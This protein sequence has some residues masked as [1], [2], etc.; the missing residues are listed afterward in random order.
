[1]KNSTFKKSRI[2]NVARRAIVP[3]AALV[4]AGFAGPAISGVTL[5]SGNSYLTIDYDLQAWY[6]SRGYTSSTTPGGLN[7]FFLRRNRIV[8]SG[9]YNNYVGFFVDTDAPVDGQQGFNDRSM[10]YAD[11]YVTIDTN[12][13]YQFI[14]G[15]FK[16]PFTRENLEDCFGALT[17]DRSLLLAY[18][19]F[20]ASRDTGVAMWG[21]FHNAMFQYRVMVSNGRQSNGQGNTPKSEPMVTGRITASLLD[22]EY[23]YGYESTYLGTMKVLTIGASYEYQQDVVWDNYAAQT[24]PKNYE[25]WTTD[26]FYEYPFHSGTYTASAAYM[27]YSTGNAINSASPDPNLP[28]TTQLQGYYVKAGYMFPRKIGIGRLQFFLRHEKSQYNL[29]TGYGDQQWNSGGFNYYIS[30]QQLK[31]TGEYAHVT[32]NTQDPLNAAMQNYNMETLGLQ[33]LF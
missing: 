7:N 25:A 9:Q 33:L 24:D 8:L 6:Q 27:H 18:T 13:A 5:H 19:P 21:N 30:G 14:V 3:L 32:F 17:M 16:I 2:A 1:M 23:G 29:L 22:P 12:D 11:A 28:L 31:V 20:A 10:T 4:L 15:K 26:I